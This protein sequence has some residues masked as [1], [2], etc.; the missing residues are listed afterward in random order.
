MRDVISD[1][2]ANLFSLVFFKL[3][4]SFLLKMQNNEN[5]NRMRKKKEKKKKKKKKKN[6]I[7]R[8]NLVIFF[9]CLHKHI[10][11]GRNI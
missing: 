5:E 10:Y 1:L 9:L 8:K 6:L 3:S 2:S 11:N 4:L 7:A